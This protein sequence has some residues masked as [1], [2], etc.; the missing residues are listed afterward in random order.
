[1]EATDGQPGGGEVAG[2]PPPPTLTVAAVARR[3]GVAPPTLRIAI[4][5]PY[6]EK[7]GL[8]FTVRLAALIGSAH[9]LISLSIKSAR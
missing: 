5:R 3:L 1:M 2:D 9:F 4:L 7:A 6:R 8:Q